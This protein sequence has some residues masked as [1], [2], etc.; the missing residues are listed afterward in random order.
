MHLLLAPFFVLFVNG[1]RMIQHLSSIRPRASSE[2]GML[3]EVW[4]LTRG[5]LV[6]YPGE[7]KK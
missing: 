2:A 1:F 7:I 6:V 5:C 4:L 3:D